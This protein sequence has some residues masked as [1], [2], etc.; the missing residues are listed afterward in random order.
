MK[1]SKIV[2][3]SLFS[4]MDLFL[5]GLK[6]VGLIPFYAV[7]RNVYAALM[8]AENFKNEYELPVIEFVEVNKE[9]YLFRKNHTDGKDKK[10]MDDTVT[11]HGGKYIRSKTIEEING[12]D[13]RK[14]IE[15]KYG[16]EVI[17][18]L[19]GGPPCQDFI[20]LNSKSNLG[21]DSRNNLV[22]E[23]LRLLSEL[24]PDIALME[25]TSE[26]ESPKNI[27]IFNQFI[28]LANQLQFKLAYQDMNSIHYTGNQ[29]RS[30]RIFQFVNN[31]LNANPIFPIAATENVKRVRDF[32]SIDYF[33]SGHYIDKIKTKNDFMCTV[34]SGSPKWFKKGDR[35]WRPT[36]NELL[37]C[38]DVQSGEYIIPDFIPDGQVRKAIGNGVCVSLSQALI[39]TVLHSVLKVKPQG[40]GIFI[41]IDST[42]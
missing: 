39:T 4:G 16:S 18:V 34:T 9:E 10:D 12:C 13:I 32:L 30:R 26:I 17:I 42:T 28:E 41:P 21:F 3:V 40:D 38:M 1:K 33:F 2:V 27:H 22:F 29:S 23:Y 25:Q 36:I 35:K 37:L 6:K 14:S 11:Q 24:N 15:K 7:E 20:R 8:H 31:R 5:L 19:I